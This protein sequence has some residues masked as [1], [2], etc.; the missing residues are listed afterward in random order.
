MSLLPISMTFWDYD[1]VRALADGTVRIEGCDAVHLDL[2][3]HDIFWR[4][5][6]NQEFDVTEMSFSSYMMMLSAGDPPYTAIPVFL[7][8]MFRHS[9]IY[10]RTDRDINAPAD[11]KGREIG[12]PEYQVTAALWARGI[13]SDEYGVRASDIRWRTGGIEDP[14][15]PEKL[16]LDMPEDIEVKPIPDDK[17]LSGMLEAGEI[18]GMVSPLPPSCFLNKAPNVARLFPNFREDE[19]AYYKKTGFYPIMHVAA[20]R[21]EL[22][23]QHR[24]LAN[25]VY[26]AF[27]KAKAIAMPKLRNY[28]AVKATVP[29]L[30]AEVDETIALMGEDY[31]PYGVDKNRDVL[32]AMTRYSWEQGLSPRKLGV[33]ELFAPE[34]YEQSKS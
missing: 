7:S 24:W 33:D 3:I 10:I 1:R 29:W 8:R 32:D 17:S 5:I 20:I 15:R 18:D 6:R 25:N 30:A 12:V 21:T 16:A 23:R 26:E 27:E 4:A 13:L 9:A 28:G 14:G 31:W 19:K 34:T 22:L 11:L 2:D